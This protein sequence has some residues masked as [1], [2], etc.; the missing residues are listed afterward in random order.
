[1]TTGPPNTGGG[2]HPVLVALGRALRW[3]AG[4]LW[5]RAI[6]TVGLL[7]LVFSQIDWSELGRALREGRW[8]YFAIAV[9]VMFV[10]LA[11]GGLRWHLLLRAAAVPTT[12]LRTLHAYAV[13][14]FSNLFLPTS[15]GGDAARAWMIG[16]SGRNLAA[17]AATVVVDRL[18]AVACLFVLAW[19]AVVA[20]PSEIP[21]ELV[22]ALAVIT[23]VGTLAL[24]LAV[25]AAGPAR[26]RVARFVPSRARG[27]LGEAWRATRA[28]LAPNLRTVQVLALGFVFQGLVVVELWAL[29]RAIRMDLA[30]AL[31]AVAVAIVLVVTMIPLSIAG[32]GLREGGYVLVLGAA[33]YGATQAA[34]L[35]VLTFVALALA[36]AP[37]A[38]ALLWPMPGAPPRSSQPEGG[39]G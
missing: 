37:G 10:A 2:R 31:A 23:L 18:S 29:A 13:G 7:A 33:G 35:S 24:G 4:S 16:R 8:G 34:L 32:F 21:G 19:V 26:A 5:V 27:A 20:E 36:S 17:A 9:G 15:M 14:I 25:V 38:L 39:S 28:S 6:A 22:V 1:M 11:C 3:A 30:L 12:P